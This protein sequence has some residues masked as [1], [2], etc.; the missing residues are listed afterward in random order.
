MKSVSKKRT[1]I[2]NSILIIVAVSF[3]FYAHQNGITG[4]TL[5]GPEPGCTC[6]A[7]SPSTNVNVTINGPDELLIGETADYSVT[8]TGGILTRGGTNIAV[9]DGNL[10]PGEGLQK[11]SGELTHTAPK[12]P[13]QNAVTFQFTYTAPSA[14]ST[15]TLYANGNSV[16]FNGNELGD[17]WNYATNKTITVDNPSSVDDELLADNFF[18]LQNYPNPFNPSTKITFNIP[19]SGN[20]RLVIFNSLGDEVNVIADEFKSAGA[21]T[22]NFHSADLAS[23]VYYYRLITSKNT[24]T[25]KMLILK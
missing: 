13:E 11:I 4:R 19:E 21:Y 25:K 17:S 9:S 7:L 6:H 16:N 2:P 20:V 10:E 12:L 3:V 18:L 5:K 22:Y 24:E 15:I 8:I 14:P 1:F 23:G